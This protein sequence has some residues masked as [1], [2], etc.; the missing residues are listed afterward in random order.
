MMRAGGAPFA[1][2]RSVNVS[3]LVWR[4]LRDL[5]AVMKHEHFQPEA[6]LDPQDLRRVRTRLEQVD[7]ATFEANRQ[8]LARTVG[9][10]DIRSF[11]R[12][13]AASALARGDWVTA[14]LR[15]T[16]Q[17]HTPSAAE[18]AKLAQLRA[19]FEELTAAY[20][21]LRRMVERGYLC[22]LDVA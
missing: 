5:G 21:A 16:E 14:A 3:N 11:Q 2:A 6:A 8:H 19:T 7:T 20:D 4:R 9:R 15:A 18:I 10:V 17:S 12:L 1:A 13:A 22:F